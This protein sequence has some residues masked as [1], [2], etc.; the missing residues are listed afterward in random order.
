[1]AFALSLAGCG[2][3]PPPPPEE[4]LD[5]AAL[6]AEAEKAPRTLLVLETPET[7][8]ALEDAAKHG[9]AV[10]RFDGCELE[11]LRGCDGLG[12]YASAPS[13]EDARELT[14]HDTRRAFA[15]GIVGAGRVERDLEQ[16]RTLA[17]ELRPATAL[18][19]KAPPAMLSG[20]CAG[21]THWVRAIELGASSAELEA[22]GDDAPRILTEHGEPAACGG[23]R[24]SDP[25]SD[26]ACRRPWAISLERIHAR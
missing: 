8:A 21:A 1:M 22:R 12:S 3:S 24:A 13:S 6:C 4:R 19:A 23:A 26:R 9:I 20:E 15:E 11:V 25:A 5:P 16:G 18:T 10:V 7:K 14:I 2:S 17:I